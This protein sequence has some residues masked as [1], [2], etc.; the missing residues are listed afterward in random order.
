M[1][2][3]RLPRS[4]LL[5]AASVGALVFAAVAVIGSGVAA[6]LWGTGLIAAGWPLYRLVRRRAVA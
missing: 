1:A 2:R 3:G 4:W 5:T 6:I